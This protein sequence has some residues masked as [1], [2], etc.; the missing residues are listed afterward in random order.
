[1]R[2]PKFGVGHVIDAAQHVTIE[3]GTD[4][5][6]LA[7]VAQ[8]AAPIVPKLRPNKPSGD[9]LELAR[10]AGVDIKRVPARFDEEK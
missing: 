10:A 6:M 3:I 5:K 1:V 7:H 4:R 8:I 9:T 2:H